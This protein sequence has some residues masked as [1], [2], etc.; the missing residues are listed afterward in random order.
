MILG[1]MGNQ[2]AHRNYS[3][4]L[5]FVIVNRDDRRSPSGAPAQRCDHNAEL[6]IRDV[7]LPLSL[8][9]SINFRFTKILNLETLHQN[10]LRIHSEYTQEYTTLLYTTLRYTR[11]T[12]KCVQYADL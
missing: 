11:Y 2:C 6:G 3:S 8:S 10:T 12:Q 4:L 7:R 1:T 5:D 9:L